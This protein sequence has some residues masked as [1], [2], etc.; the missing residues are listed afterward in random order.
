ML[1]YGFVMVSLVFV[2]LPALSSISSVLSLMLV[3][4]RFAL[5]WAVVLNFGRGE[6]SVSWT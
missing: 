5:S 6:E 1:A 2:R 3:M 4:P